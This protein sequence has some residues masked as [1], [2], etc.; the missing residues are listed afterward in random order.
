MA[1]SSSQMIRQKSSLFQGLRMQSELVQ[2]SELWQEPED[3]SLVE[4]SA[5]LVG[6]GVRIES[7]TTASVGADE[8]PAAS[9]FP[10]RTG[11]SSRLMK[12]Y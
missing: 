1:R 2:P 6:T 8:D 7:G 4:E 11:Q 10:V 12:V 9:L 3:L 5:T